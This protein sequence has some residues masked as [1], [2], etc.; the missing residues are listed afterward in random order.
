MFNSLQT[1]SRFRQ[2]TVVEF[3]VYCR[4]ERLPPV[5]AIIDRVL[6]ANPHNTHGTV[7]P[8]NEAILFS[9]VRLRLA[10]SLRTRNPMLFDLTAGPLSHAPPEFAELAAHGNAVAVVRFVSEE[11]IKGW[12]YVHFL[13][14]LAD[15]LADLTDGQVFDVEADRFWSNEEWNETMM[16]DA[17]AFRLENQAVIHADIHPKWRW[18]HSH[19]LRKFG[20]PDLEVVDVPH[21][22]GALAHNLLWHIAELAVDSGSFPKAVESEMFGRHELTIAKVRKDGAPHHR[23]KVAR[24]SEEK[25]LDKLSGLLE[26]INLDPPGASAAPA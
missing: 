7:V 5:E 8:A 13:T 4:A 15:A 12:G 9:D 25:F 16:S 21:E 24:L 17:A 18:V 6:A 22:Q 23:G 2:A 10:L 3:W 19:G 26:S 11:R 1:S 20:L 14:H